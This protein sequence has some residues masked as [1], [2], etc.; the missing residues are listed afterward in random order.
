MN[1]SVYVRINAKKYGQICGD[2]HGQFFDLMEKQNWIV[3][4][5]KG[6]DTLHETLN[7]PLKRRL[8]RRE[9]VAPAK[10][11]RVDEAVLKGRHI[12]KDLVNGV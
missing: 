2:I 12:L 4:L 8:D 7:S 10:K 3:K 9:G 11:V 5:P 6:A 1:Y